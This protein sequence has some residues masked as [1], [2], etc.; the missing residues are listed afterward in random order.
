MKSPLGISDFLKRSLVF[1]ILLFSSISL[2][3]SLRKACFLS[4][5][6]F[7]TQNIWGSLQFLFVKFFILFIFPSFHQSLSVFSCSSLKYYLEFFIRKIRHLYFLC[8]CYWK[9]IIFFDG[10]IFSWPFLFPGV[11]H[12]NVQFWRSSHILLSLLIGFRRWMSSVSP[13]RNP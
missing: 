13:V 12:Y 5:L 6:F 1:P 4:L 2:H 3:W 11:S 10:V 9:I 7:G 8:V